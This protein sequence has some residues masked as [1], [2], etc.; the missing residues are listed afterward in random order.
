MRFVALYLL[1]FCILNA[2]SDA[3]TEATKRPLASF[4]VI[5]IP[6][7]DAIS[8]FLVDSELTELIENVEIIGVELMVVEVTKT[9]PFHE[10]VRCAK[11]TT[12]DE[13][14]KIYN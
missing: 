14:Q 12:D 9:G 1:T 4:S 8:Q 2:F 6:L 3:F 11:M 5:D 7:E 10:L 13:R